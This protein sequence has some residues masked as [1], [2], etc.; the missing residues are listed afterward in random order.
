[1]AEQLLSGYRVLD[2]ASDGVEI[3]AT[4]LADLGADVIKVEPPWGDPSRSIGP[5]PVSY[6]HAG[7]EAAVAS[8]IAHWHREKTG[9]TSRTPR[10]RTR[11]SS[12]RAPNW[13]HKGSGRR[14]STPSSARRSPTRATGCASTTSPSGAPAEHPSSASTPKRSSPGISDS[15]LG[16]HN[17]YVYREILGY[18]DDEITD[19]VASQ[20]ITNEGQVP[21][22]SFM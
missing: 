7:V 9:G 4:V 20:V 18:T 11:R 14:S 10:S 3:G 12:G 1:M 6:L 13:R 5:S 16:Q 22:R 8:L 19:L 2:L 21:S 17:A 15:T